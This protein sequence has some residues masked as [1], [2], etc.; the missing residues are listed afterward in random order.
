MKNTENHYGIIT[1]LLHW[2][3]AAIIIGLFGLGYWMVGLGY[4]DPWYKQGPDLHK[5][6]GAT[7]FLLM[8]GRVLWRKLQ[9]QPKGLD[10]HTKFEKTAGAVVHQF[11]Y[12]VIFIIMISGYLISTADGRAIEVFQF[13]QVPSLGELFSNQ[14]D[15]AG[16]VH[17]YLAYSL[18]FVVVLH[19][20]AA[21]KH[22]FIDKD[23]TLMRMLGQRKS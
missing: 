7:L 23:N 2:L 17:K 3:V 12:L 4:Y 21:L 18:I 15:I 6:I 16:A 11:L 1:I 13:I 10:S 14:E 22:H 5:S 8:I 9:V 19:A 20:A